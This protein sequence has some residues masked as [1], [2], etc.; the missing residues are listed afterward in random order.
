MATAG[1]TLTFDDI[2]TEDQLATSIANRFITW[3]GSRHQ[4]VSDWKEQ[5]KYIYAKDTTKTAN[6]S[7]PWKNKTTI[8]KLTQIRDNLAANYMA[9]IFPKRKF[10]KW[11]SERE[12][13]Q[14]RDKTKAILSYSMYMIDYPGFKDTVTRLL[15]DYID[16]GNVFA[17]VDW[18]DERVETDVKIQSGYVGPVIQRISPYDIVFNPA[19]ADFSRTPKIIRSIVTLGDLQEYLQR[20]SA[21]D[22]ASKVAEDTFNYLLEIRG[23]AATFAAGLQTQ[24]ELYSFDGFGSLSAYLDSGTAEVLTFY[25]DFYDSEANKFYKN[26]IITVVDRHKVVRNEPNPSDAG[27]PPI[28][29][30]GWRLRQDNLWAMGPLEN[31]VGMQYRLD[32][33][34]NLKSDFFDIVYAPPVKIRGHVEPF[35]WAPM[36]QIYMGDDG[37]VELLSPTMNPMQANFEMDAL[38]AKM[39]SLA[40]APKEALGFRTPG[41]KTAYEVQRLENAAARVFQSKISQFEEQVIEPLLNDMIELAR[42]KV[43]ETTVRVLND[44]LMTTSFLTLTADQLKGA[45]RIRPIAARHYA[46]VAERVQSITQFYQTVGADPEVRAHISSQKIAR[47]FE[48]MLDFGEFK[49]VEPYIRLTEQAEAQSLQMQNEE[50]TLMTASTPS[51]LTPEDTDVPFA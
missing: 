25:G 50:D 35:V 5:Y 1:N 47:A 26:H 43:D 22:G 24:S 3:D 15:Y 7:L 38:E 39:E 49:M 34:E 11:I 41:E 37:D 45:G 6:S 19:A 31:L 14:T 42:R 13:D 21:D 9:G 2:I 16:H 18:L 8:P 36:E 48:D 23:R 32:H 17:T 12:D 27:I 4:V 30:S 10:L 51:G 46:E 44:E 40:G 20:L 33:I 28:R 29:H